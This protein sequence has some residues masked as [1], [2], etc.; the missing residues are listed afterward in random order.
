[1]E[2][3]KC[4]TEMFL[5][6][7]KT[8]LSVPLEHINFGHDFIEFGLYIFC[9]YCF[10]FIIHCVMY[11]VGLTSGSTFSEIRLQGHYESRA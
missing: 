7:T 4:C 11:I 8:L 5:L 3:D 6:K 1:M 2:F 10:V 9:S